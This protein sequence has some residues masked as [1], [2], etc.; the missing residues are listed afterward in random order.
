MVTGWLLPSIM[1]PTKSSGTSIRQANSPASVRF[2][3]SASS[4]KTNWQILSTLSSVPNIDTAFFA[5]PSSSGTTTPTF[6]LSSFA[7]LSTVRKAKRAMEP[8]SPAS[9]IAPAA[10]HGRNRRALFSS[11]FTYTKNVRIFPP[12]A[13]SDKPPPKIR[14][15]RFIIISF[16]SSS[17]SSSEAA[18][19]SISSPFGAAISL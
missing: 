5:S 10:I 15:Y 8:S 13:Y 6:S 9:T 7:P 16:S 19:T 1:L 18:S 3:P 12:V 14:E 2:F 11:N 17:Q 4:V